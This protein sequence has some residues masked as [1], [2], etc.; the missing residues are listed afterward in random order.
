MPGHAELHETNA[1]PS[2]ENRPLWQLVVALLPPIDAGTEWFALTDIAPLLNLSP[3]ALSKH[4][5][6]LWPRH[7]GHWRLNYSQATAV[8]RRV[9]TAGRKR[10]QRADLVARLERAGEYGPHPGGGVQ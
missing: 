1:P 5:R 4:C 2:W 9:C 7:E 10:P 8:I 3:H 6:D